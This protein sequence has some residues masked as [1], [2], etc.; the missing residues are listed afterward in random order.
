MKSKI[1]TLE[2]YVV[3]IVLSMVLPLVNNVYSA[4]GDVVVRLAGHRAVKG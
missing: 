3:P 4:A 2:S 1:Q